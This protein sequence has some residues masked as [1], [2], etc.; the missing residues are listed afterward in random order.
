[1][2]WRVVLCT[3][4]FQLLGGPETRWPLNVYQFV[5]LSQPHVPSQVEG[6]TISVGAIF[7]VPQCALMHPSTGRFEDREVQWILADLL[8][9]R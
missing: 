2:A 7:T 4:D 1:M 5:N 6:A 8:A 3:V 9:F